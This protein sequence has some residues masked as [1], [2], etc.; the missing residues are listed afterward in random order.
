MS[1][2]P[3]AAGALALA[4]PPEAPSLEAFR[5]EHEEEREGGAGGAARAGDG[6]GE[7]HWEKTG[8]P[9][10]EGGGGAMGVVDG[11]GMEDG[12]V[13]AGV[14]G[15]LPKDFAC[16][17]CIRVQ[18]RLDAKRQEEELVGRGGAGGAGGRKGRRRRGGK[19]TKSLAQRL[20]CGGAGSRTSS[21]ASSHEVEGEGVT[22]DE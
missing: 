1:D 16:A 7:G 15:Q 11:G 8:C 10:G 13:D 18:Q 17:V 14:L 12:G 9:E 5:G 22:G 4:A 6:A 21:Q 20:A 2:T 19:K 3:A